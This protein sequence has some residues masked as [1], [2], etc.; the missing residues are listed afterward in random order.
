MEKENVGANAGASAPKKRRLS[1]S[2]KKRSRC[3]DVSEEPVES[4]ACASIPKNSALNSKWAMHNLS[5]WLAHHNKRHPE[6]P[7]P[8][9]T[10]SSSF[11]KDVLSIWLPVFVLETRNQRGKKYPPKTL[12][13]LLCGILREMRVQNPNYPNYLDKQDS[14]FAAFL[15][16]VNNLLKSLREFGVGS[17]SSHTEEISTEEESLLRSSGVLNTTMPKGLLRAV[18]YVCGK[19]FCLRGGQEHRDLAPSQFERLR[20]PYCYVYRENTLNNKQGG[21]RQL[22]LEHKVIKIVANPA[23]K[24]KCPVYIFDLYLSKLPDK[25]KESDTFYCR[26]LPCIPAINST[27]PWFSAVPVGR[28]I[29]QNMV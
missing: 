27:E 7:C 25:A 9:E 29:L 23:V 14:T 26:P 2:L 15:N 3:A 20:D 22:K 8:P 24:E 19:C 5:E 21:L 28:N 12:Y 1:L 17:T 13:N 18:F 16:T 11:P 4:F 6:S 10:V